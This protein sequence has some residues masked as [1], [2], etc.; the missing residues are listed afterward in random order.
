MKKE[1]EKIKVNYLFNLCENHNIIRIKIIK[2]F[3]II[4][5]FKNI[6]T[7]SGLSPSSH[8]K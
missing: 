2:Y 7:F 3:N 6:I 5:N 1:K 4:F 8:V